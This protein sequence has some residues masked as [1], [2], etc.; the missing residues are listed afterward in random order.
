[1]RSNLANSPGVLPDESLIRLSTQA[2]AVAAAIIAT[3]WGLL[4]TKLYFY[5]EKFS[6]RSAFASPLK[7]IHTA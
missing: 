7:P 4:V 5:P 6:L 3:L 1:M 2:F